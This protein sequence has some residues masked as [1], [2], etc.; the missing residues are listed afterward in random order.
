MIVKYSLFSWCC[1]SWVLT[2]V[3]DIIIVAAAKVRVI[4]IIHYK[5]LIKVFCETDELLPC[6][7]FS[8]FR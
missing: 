1:N 3:N 7:M 8:E 4:F 2:A 5:F 6:C